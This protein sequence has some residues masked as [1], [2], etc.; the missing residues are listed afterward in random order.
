MNTTKQYIPNEFGCLLQ[1]IDQPIQSNSFLEK[2]KGGVKK[3]LFLEIPIKTISEGNCFEPWQTRHRRHKSQKKAVFY[4]MLPIKYQLGLPCTITLIRQASRF[5]DVGDNLPMS[6][7]F[8]RDGIAEQITGDFVPGRA[9][10]NPGFTWKYDQEK[11]KKYGVKI[12][13]EF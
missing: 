10:N 9:D 2:S 3:S 1:K 12:I 5:L 6:M 11:S 4:A 13:F 8:I 7:K